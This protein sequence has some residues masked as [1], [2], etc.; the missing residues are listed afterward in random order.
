[1]SERLL[2]DKMETEANGANSRD[3]SHCRRLSRSSSNQMTND[4]PCIGE[5]RLIAELFNSGIISRS[6]PTRGNWLAENV[7][8]PFLLYVRME[9]S[10]YRP[11]AEKRTTGSQAAWAGDRLPVAPIF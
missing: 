11:M 7:P 1:M 8:V 2:K 5:D 9:E 6:P 10:R 4:D 3:A